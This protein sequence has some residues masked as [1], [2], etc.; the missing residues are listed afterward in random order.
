M[1]SFFIGSSIDQYLMTKLRKLRTQHCIARIIENL[2]QSLWPCGVWFTNYNARRNPPVY[3]YGLHG[4]PVRSAPVTAAKF[5]NPWSEPADER[6]VAARV[7]M[8]L[9]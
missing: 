3:K 9:K 5:L 6:V 4:A 7:K 8:V 2:Q 1:L